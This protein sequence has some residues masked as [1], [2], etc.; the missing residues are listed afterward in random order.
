MANKS[1]KKKLSARTAK[2]M[3]WSGK[4]KKTPSGL[5]KK[6]LIKN[7]H[8]KIVSKKKHRLGKSMMKSGN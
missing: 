2:R 5:T 6:D 8:G 7:R 1:L 4:M 3:V